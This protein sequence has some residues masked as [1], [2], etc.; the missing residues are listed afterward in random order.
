[1]LEA[2]FR[3][4]RGEFVL[5]CDFTVPGGGLGVFGPS[6]S[7][8]STLLE[9][10]AGLLRPDE[11]EIRLDGEV[12][13]GKGVDVPPERRGIALVFQDGAL[14]PHLTVRQ[15]LLYGAR[16]QGPE[17]VGFDDAV[18]LLDL[19]GLLDRK[20]PGLSGGEARRV[21]LG[22]AL[23][24]RPR[25]LVLDEPL[26]GLDEALRR[27][28]LP[29]LL[30][31]RDRLR[32]PTLF[33]SHVLAEVLALSDRILVLEKGR[34]AAL[35]A[36]REV[37]HDP[38]LFPVAEA[39]GLENVMTVDLSA[40]EPA[41]G[42]SLGT[43]AGQPVVL[44]LQEGARVRVALRA[45]DIALTRHVEA[46]SARNRWPARV[47]SVTQAPSRVLVELDLSGE[48]LLA[49]L[50]R[51]AVTELALQPGSEVT[52]VVKATSFRVLG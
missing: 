6:G 11:G 16:R 24:S 37:L 35:G 28:I 33:V 32:L 41:D 50:T 43:W 31:V 46:S 4:R 17:A 25:M 23:L 52:A 12:L 22:R 40:H 26:T 19:G 14:F 18:S 29:L 42:V 38:A 21:A 9:C 39:T 27:R 48:T 49:E 47:A 3:K 15:N 1:M 51:R 13:F 2:R 45:S 10:L 44:P 8:K 20:T 30:E 36:T 5:D 34:Q 7:G